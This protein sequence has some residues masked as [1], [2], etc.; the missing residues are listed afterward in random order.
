LLQSSA[1]NFFEY[2]KTL[3][4]YKSWGYSDFSYPQTVQ[5][6][7][8]AACPS[9]FYAFFLIFLVFLG[10]LGFFLLLKARKKEMK[11][12]FSQLS[13]FLRM[14]INRVKKQALL[15]AL[16]R[17]TLFWA[18]FSPFIFLVLLFMEAYFELQGLGMVIK[19]AY[20]QN[21][22][23]LLYGSIFCSFSFACILSM[24]FIFLK[25]ALPHK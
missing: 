23:P 1:S 15:A 3:L 8:F 19:T 5:H 24:C 22:M 18:F 9:S 14:D 17:Q 2:L 12:D 11:K 4:L 6:F 21:D 7:V 10:T 25:C 16:P 13:L 20:L